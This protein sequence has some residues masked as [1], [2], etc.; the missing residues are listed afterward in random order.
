MKQTACFMLISRFAYSFDSKYWDD[1]PPKRRLSSI[2]LHGVISQ[3]IKPF[4]ISLCFF[5]LFAIVFGR[6]LLIT[7]YEVRKYMPIITFVCASK[8]VRLTGMC[9]GRMWIIFVRSEAFTTARE[10]CIPFLRNVFFSIII[11]TATRRNECRSSSGL[12]ENW[13]GLTNSQI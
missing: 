1:A 13:N 3:K 9:I 10:N 7:E 12:S 8:I 5:F 4:K 2:G 6:P 11:L